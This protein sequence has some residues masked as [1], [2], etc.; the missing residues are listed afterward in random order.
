[1][2][3]MVITAAE[4]IAVREQTL[5]RMLVYFRDREG[6]K[7]LFVSGSLAAGTS[8]AWSDIDFRVVVAP[9]HYEAFLAERNMAPAA[10]GELLFNQVRPGSIHS[11]SHFRPFFKVDTFY[12][13]PEYLIPSPWFTLPTRVLYDPD[14]LVQRVIRQSQGLEFAASAE[15]VEL[16]IR[17]GLAAAHEVLRRASRGELA[18]AEVIL[19]ELR[20]AVIDADDY[21]NGRPWYGFSHFESRADPSV[22]AAVHG[23]YCPLEQEVILTSL[24]RLSELFGRQIV[25][26]HQQFSLSRA[27][28]EDEAAL[29]AVVRLLPGATPKGGL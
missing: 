26:L 4:I 9:E 15:R 8:D 5:D 7:A 25:Q 27:A 18:Y 19:D 17:L 28:G 12:Y 29:E 1:M 21:L 13:R 3:D 23:S 6:V 24:A 11:V 2:R 10:W 16:S 22:V 14:G 20:Q